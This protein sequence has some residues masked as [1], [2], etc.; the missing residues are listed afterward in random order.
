MKCGVAMQWNRIQC[1]QGRTFGGAK[2]SIRNIVNNNVIII[3]GVTWVL[4]ILI[5]VIML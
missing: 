2:Y 5:G 4:T 3:Y 1:S